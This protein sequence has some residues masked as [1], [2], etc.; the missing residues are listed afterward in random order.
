MIRPINIDGRQVLVTGGCGFVGSHLVRRLVQL[1]IRVTSLGGDR[2]GV[3]PTQGVQSIL[4]PTSSSISLEV[5][6]L[7]LL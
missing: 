7:P 2:E 1:G 3:E 4:S 5:P 6:P